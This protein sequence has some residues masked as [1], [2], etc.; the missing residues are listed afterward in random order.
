MNPKSRSA[1]ILTAAILILW[2]I[3]SWPLPAHF[4]TGVPQSDRNIEKHHVRK[5]I[6]G[7]QLQ[8]MYHFWLAKDMIAGKTPLFTNAYEFNQGKDEELRRPDPYYAPYSIV[9]AFFNTF[10]SR[11]AAWNIAGLLSVAV[12][13]LSSYWLVF[14]LTEDRFSAFI[15]AL[16]ASTFPYRWITLLIGSPTGFGISLIPLTALGLHI[17]VK[18]GKWTG[19]II[20]GMAV[21]FSYCSDLHVLYFNMLTLPFWTLLFLLLKKDF[22]LSAPRTCI[23]PGLAILPAVILAGLTA[24]TASAAGAH[25][26]QTDMAEGRPEKLI[27]KYSARSRGL[28]SWENHG[29]DNHVFF[30]HIALLIVLIALI[31]FTVAA[32]RRRTPLR[33]TAFFVLVLVASLCIVSLALG[34]NGIADGWMMWKC[35][36]LIPK[37]N[38]IRQP[39]KI[40]CLIPLFLAVLAGFGVKQFIASVSPK[41]HPAFWISVLAVLCLVEWRMQISPTIC[42]LADDQ[43]AYAAVAESARSEGRKPHIAAIP[44]WPGDSHWSS[45]YEHY[46]SLYRIRMLNGYSPA[47]GNDYFESVVKPLDS[48]NRGV[49]TQ[50]QIDLLRG[51]GVDYLL[52]HQ[53]AYPDQVSPYPASRALVSFLNHPN[54]SLIKQSESI[55]AFEILPQGIKGAPRVQPPEYIFSMRGWELESRGILGEYGEAVDA[56]HASGKALKLTADYAEMKSRSLPYAPGQKLALRAKG[57]GSFE[58]SIKYGAANAGSRTVEIN[59]DEWEWFTLPFESITLDFAP[60]ITFSAPKGDIY[61]DMMFLT[62]GKELRLKPGEEAVIPAG[63]LYGQGYINLSDFSVSLRKDNEQDLEILYGMFP[64]LEKGTYSV[65]LDIECSEDVEPGSLI[66]LAHN[67]QPFVVPIERPGKFVHIYKH[68]DNVPVKIGFDYGRNADMT[69]KQLKLTRLQ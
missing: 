46:V 40:Y 4:S 24:F 53:D 33:N 65:E 50:T 23:K 22:S 57:H 10:L 39:V 34:S 52:F 64:L 29:I 2:G 63:C 25:L 62:A 37:Y 67:T 59:N 45:L 6:P 60:T 66:Y 38:M 44:L 11:A 49:L 8:L 36:D 54:L 18:D 16:L 42:L 69:V 58:W 30:G 48:V 5:M 12:M 20:A 27:I 55:W 32:L 47:I 17:A 3:F 26:Q 61:L 9:F 51:M 56:E 19:G 35:R 14:R 41:R 15:A 1:L 68:P 28:F 21:F 31:S 13:L 43:P 7:D